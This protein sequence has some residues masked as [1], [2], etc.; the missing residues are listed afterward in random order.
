MEAIISFILNFLDE[1]SPFFIVNQYQNAIILR[2]GIYTDK[3][4][5][6]G[7]FFKIPYFDEVL[8][9]HI[10]VTTLSLPV[11][12]LVT[13]DD[14]PIVVKGVVKYKI[15]DIKLFLLEVYDAFDAI[16]D[17]A[18]SIIAKECNKKTWEE[19]KI[20]DIDNEI[21]K[22]LRSNLKQWGIYIESVTLTDK[23]P[24]RSF[25]LFNEQNNG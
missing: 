23:T 22:K 7:I 11:Q 6:K 18:Q 13:Q 24:S 10:V 21:T 16:G 2:R 4:Y 14:K 1:L 8:K 9:Q 19:I 3:I 12:S 25:R 15:E 20:E 17:T 5:T